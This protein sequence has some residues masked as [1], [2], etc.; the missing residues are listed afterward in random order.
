MARGHA[1]CEDDFRPLIEAIEAE[2]VREWPAPRV[3]EFMQ[4]PDKKNLARAMGWAIEH[5]LLHNRREGPRSYYV[6]GPDP[7]A[8]EQLGEFEPVLF[9][10]GTL[11]LQN[12]PL[13]EHDEP[14]LNRAQAARLKRLLSGDLV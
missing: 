2:G 9:G 8:P 7:T 5:G 12:C 10:D 6:L 14:Q 3:Q 4:I 1:L 11:I 13:N